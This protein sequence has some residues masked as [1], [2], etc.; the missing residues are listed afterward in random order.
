[1]EAR[2]GR[3][4]VGASGLRVLCPAGHGQYLGR[5]VRTLRGPWG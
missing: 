3:H 5:A 4:T 1:M 2:G